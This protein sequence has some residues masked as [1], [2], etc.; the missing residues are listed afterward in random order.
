M[1]EE[2]ETLVCLLAHRSSDL[3]PGPAAPEQRLLRH[4]VLPAEHLAVM[5]RE[6]PAADLGAARIDHHPVAVDHVDPRVGCEVAADVGEGAQQILR[7]DRPGGQLD[8]REVLLLVAVDEVV[9]EQQRGRVD[10]EEQAAEHAV[11]V[12]EAGRG[13]GAAGGRE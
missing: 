8:D 13:G 9:A 7:L 6:D 3:L 4:V 5:R 10:A 1:S 11:A 2:A 12:G